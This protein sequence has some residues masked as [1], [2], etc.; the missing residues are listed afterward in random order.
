MQERSQREV[1]FL[2]KAPPLAAGI[3]TYN[4]DGELTGKLPTQFHSAVTGQGSEGVWVVK[5]DE[6]APSKPNILAQ[7]STDDTDY[8]FPMAVLD[9][10]SFKDLDVSVKF[11]TISGRVDQA[12]GLVFRYQDQNNY[13]IVRANA[14]EDNYRL[15]HIVNGRRR[16]FAGANFRV[17][18]NEWHTLRVE[19]VGNQIKCYYDGELKITATDDTFKEAGKVGLWTKADSVTHFDDFIITAK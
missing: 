2:P 13:Y 1:S 12:A 4:F 10:G 16:Q 8:R 6:S 11:K 9:E 19:C 3:F 14:L 5:Q 15:Y 17:T 18:P 7:T